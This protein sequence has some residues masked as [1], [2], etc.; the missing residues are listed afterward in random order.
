MCTV[1]RNAKTRREYCSTGYSNTMI[2][3][4]FSRMSDRT[5][6]YLRLAGIILAAYVLL[7]LVVSFLLDGRHAEIIVLGDPVVTIDI[8]TTYQDPGAY[9]VTD[10]RLFGEGGYL[11]VSAEGGYDAEHAGVYAIIY[12]VRYLGKDYYAQRTIIVADRIPPVIELQHTEGYV[13]TWM[14]GYVEEGFIATD[15]LDGDLTAQVQVIPQESS[16]L[17]TVTDSSG[18]TA[19]VERDLSTMVRPQLLLNGGETLSVPTSHSFDDPGVTVT[20]GAGND[21]SGLVRVEGEVQPYH[22]G[23]Y[24]LTYTLTNPMGDMVQAVRT[25][26]VSGADLSAVPTGRTIYLTFDDGPGPYTARLLDLL[27]E[28]QVKVTFFVTNDYPAY[29]DMI[30]RAFREGH[31]IGVHAYNHNYYTIYASKDAYLQDFYAMQNIIYA[32]T[33]SY[34][35]LFRFPGGSSN[36]ISRF[37]PGIMTELARDMTEMGYY[38]FDWH[39]TSGDAGE[40]EDTDTVYANI[41]AGVQQYS[42]AIVLQHDIKDFSVAAV[43]RVIQ[44]GL[45][46][47][48]TF[49]ALQPGSPDAHHG[50]AN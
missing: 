25:V 1:P 2:R 22:A 16:V 29:A 5:K 42:Q 9:A 20:D 35:D 21:L 3:S 37:N 49:A 6:K 38:Y 18:N 45:A 11:K 32:Q 36:T 4:L 47:G 48:Y 50:I 14:T 44:W 7:I 10:G 12:W 34:T 13:P 8:G 43:E 27:A 40:T 19:N 23:T 31:S 26:V 46:N 15:N 17:Y 39:V 41:V 28:Y 24:Q 33:G 30:G